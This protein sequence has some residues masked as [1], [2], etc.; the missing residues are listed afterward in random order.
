[1]NVI[2]QI[3]IPHF[4][5]FFLF[6]FIILIQ[7][8]SNNKRFFLVFLLGIAY[9]PLAESITRLHGLDPLIPWELGKYY[10]IFMFVFL[11]F[12]RKLRYDVAFF[13]GL[14]IIIST[15]LKGGTEWKLF[16]FNASI[17]SCI[18]FMWGFFKNIKISR[19][20]LLLSVKFSLLTLLVFSLSSINKLSDFKPEDVR[21]SSKFILDEIP[22]NQIATYMGLGLFL[23]VLL[24]KER[25]GLFQKSLHWNLWV[26]MGMI[27]IGI[28]SFSRGGIVVG[29]LGILSLYFYD[30]KSIT[31]FKYIKQMIVFVPL[32]V[33]LFFYINSRTNG[34]LLLRYSGETRGTIAGS[35]EKNINTL[36]TNRY[37]IMLGDL[38]TFQS[39]WIWGVEVG[40]SKE[41]RSDSEHQFSHVEFSR[42]LSEHGIIGLA[43]FILLIQ[44][45]F[46][47]RKAQFGLI[48][49]SIYLVG[50]LTTFHGA[51]R[52]S[53]PLVLMLIPLVRIDRKTVK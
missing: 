20:F 33:S 1:M 39:N 17:I 31:Q 32:I 24:F 25:S 4:W 9:F 41:Y 51:T 48:K 19:N 7:S 43:V 18:M 12:T 53:L 28:I 6:Y 21:L 52:T 5:I 47:L 10:G 38:R 2:P 30:L 26:G 45:L 15:L 50:F 35:K 3:F 11:L 14:L 27:I 34:L 40:R 46:R 42:L 49:F 23:C 16:F 36:T 22:S 37:N 8:F 44:H 13:L 29:I